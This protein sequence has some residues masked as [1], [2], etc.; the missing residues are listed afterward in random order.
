MK[1]YID[2]CSLSSGTVFPLEPGKNEKRFGCLKFENG[3]CPC[4]EY[5]AKE[6][7]TYEEKRIN[8]VKSVKTKGLKKGFKKIYQI[9]L[10]KM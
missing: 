4:K 10:L 5:N 8:Q 2:T 1:D 7:K 3:K 6:P 9:I